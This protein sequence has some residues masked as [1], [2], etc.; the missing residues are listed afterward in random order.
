MRVGYEKDNWL[1]I[2]LFFMLYGCRMWENLWPWNLSFESIREKLMKNV[3]SLCALYHQ[4][5]Y[6][7]I[8]FFKMCFIS[9][10]NKAE[11]LRLCMISDIM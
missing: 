3:H 8:T 7:I 2:L 11:H 1:Y 4:Y 9:F 10:K 5:L 6:L